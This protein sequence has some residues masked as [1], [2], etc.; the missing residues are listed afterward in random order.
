MDVKKLAYMYGKRLFTEVC[1]NVTGSKMGLISCQRCEAGP[2][3]YVLNL[4][5]IRTTTFVLLFLVE[6][7]VCVCEFFSLCM[8]Q[9]VLGGVVQWLDVRCYARQSGGGQPFLSYKYRLNKVYG[10]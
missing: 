8:L 2:L 9:A 4:K 5:P 1:R 6:K 3:S 7:V 10:F